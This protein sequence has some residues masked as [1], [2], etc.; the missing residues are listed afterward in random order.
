MLSWSALLYILSHVG[1][2]V[3]YS[4]SSV[5][6]LSFDTFHASLIVVWYIPFSSL[7]LAGASIFDPLPYPI[8]YND[9]R[10]TDTISCL[11]YV[12]PLLVWSIHRRCLC[13]K[14]A[15]VRIIL[16]LLSLCANVASYVQLSN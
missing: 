1:M 12:V 14:V 11:T 16:A 13:N 7:T 2:A 4:S 15:C 8:P 10:N 3:L 9:P 6:R 5:L